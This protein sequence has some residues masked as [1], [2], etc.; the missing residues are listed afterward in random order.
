MPTA[1]RTDRPTS[2]TGVLSDE[3]LEVVEATI[4][5]ITSAM[6]VTL[7]P[8]QV[9][10]AG[11]R[12]ART[13]FTQPRAVLRRA[14]ALGAEQVK[15]AAG[16]SDL[17]AGAKDRR[18]SDDWY[19]TNPIFRRLA[20]SQVALERAAGE[21]IDDL[22]MDDK[23][24]LRSELIA[25]LVTE[26]VSPSNSLAGNPAALKEAVR[27]RAAACVDGARHAPA[28]PQ[29]QRRHAVDG[30]HASRSC[31]G[32]TVAATPGAVVFRNRVLELIQYGPMTQQVHAAADP[33]RPAAGQPVLRARPG[34][35]T[36]P[37]AST[38]L[39]AGQQTFLVSWRNPQPEQRDWDLDTYVAALLE[40]SDAVL[41]ITG[42]ARPTTCSASAPAA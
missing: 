8:S 34:P 29:G 35:R 22:K 23:S 40:A 12:L 41:A 15:I 38:S 17:T 18:F 26:A 2:T 11:D 10:A 4:E 42:P 27:T 21:L 24:R 33:R 39:G 13:A 6:P 16:V 20:Q 9:V 3:D 37:R 14:T 19:R 36:Q 1:T 7:S 28:R 30:R 31:S 25:S 5:A 32:E